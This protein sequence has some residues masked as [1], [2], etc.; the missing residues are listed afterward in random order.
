MIVATIDIGTNTALLLIAEVAADGQV[1][2]LHEERRFVRLGE[3]V[4]ATG[5]VTPQAMARLR[6]ALLAYRGVAA[7]WEAETVLVGATSASRDARN[8][9][10][11]VA[12][13]QCETGLRYEVLTGDEE[14]VLSFAGATSAFPA[15]QGRCAVLDIGGG[16]TELIVGPAGALDA[17]AMTYH[18]S[19]DVGS[20]RLTE[21][22]FGS[23]PPSPEAVAAAEQI[24][25][26]HLAEAAPPLSP[27]VP[28]IG[29]AGTVI[30]LAL[31]HAGVSAWSDLPE[32]GTALSYAAVRAW[33][34]RLLAL[35]YDEVLALDPAVMDGRAD[36]FPAGVLILETIM[37][38]A[39][40]PTCLASPRGL[41][42]GLAFR[43]AQ[44]RSS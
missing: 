33:R 6:E 9:A 17:E 30:V 14:A 37:R 23:Q 44:H 5:Q 34:E 21:R 26:R 16:S 3:G 42:H 39:D 7:Q 36:V 27:G 20:V 12:F 29:A 22:C 18:R 25:R 4:D 31:V 35:P 24:V 2:P 15:L 40:L 13:V 10:D 19:L 28:L 32:G 38:H 43:F 1:M 8:R 41:R 11:L